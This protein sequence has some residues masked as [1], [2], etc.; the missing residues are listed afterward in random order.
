M[1]GKH[2]AIIGASA[3]VGLECVQVAL[4]R[5]HRVTVLSRSPVPAPDHPSLTRVKGS[6]THVDDLRRALAGVDAVL[7][8]LGV[9]KKLG[10]TTLFSDFGRALLQ[11]QDELGQTPVL[12]LSGFGA[13][14]SAAYQGPVASMLFK[15][16]LGRVYEDKTALER[17]VE[18]SRLHWILVRPG[19]LTNGPSTH[20]ARA[21]VDYRQ[22]MKVGSISRRTVADFMVTQAEQPTM[23]GQKPALSAR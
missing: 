23:I 4:A 20:P 19:V 3:G 2:L 8:C 22:G 5:G 6:A 17:Q 21:Q 12:V 16:F 13:G 9:G 1:H 11:L 18:G 10:A 7:V 15:V 14:D